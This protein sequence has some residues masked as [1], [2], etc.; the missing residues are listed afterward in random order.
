[1]SVL[2]LQF[3]L[4]G[5]EV[6]LET[7]HTRRLVD[8]LREDLD[9]TGTKEGCGIGECGACSVLLDGRPVNACLVMA[10]QVEGREVMTIEDLRNHPDGREL[11][12]GF[13]REGVIQCGYCIPGMLMSSYALLQENRR[14][15]RDEVRRA[16]SG[17]LCRCTGYVPVV[18]AVLQT[19]ERGEG[20]SDDV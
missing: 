12:D 19:A 17:N 14:P 16:I 8:L 2:R 13:V 9:L 10:G 15:T 3:K 7:D 11:Q 4:N 18:D 5:R 20:G 6:T 1:M